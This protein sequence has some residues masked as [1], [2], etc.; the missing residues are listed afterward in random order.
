MLN[1]QCCTHGC[2]LSGRHLAFSV[3]TTAW[4]V[5]S[6]LGFPSARP[7]VHGGDL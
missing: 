6:S 3:V 1:A 2:S 5:P 7:I 4:E